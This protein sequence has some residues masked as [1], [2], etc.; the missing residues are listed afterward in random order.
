M[1]AAL[2]IAQTMNGQTQLAPSSA[3]ELAGDLAPLVAQLGSPAGL[4]T[5]GAVSALLQCPGIDD[6]ASLAR[7]LGVYRDQLL[8]PVELPAIFRAWRHASRFECRELIALDQQLAQEPM[9]R[10]FAVA[11]RHAGRNQL[12]RLRPL[13]DEKRVQ[14][15][16]KAIEAGEAN[17]WHTPVYGATLAIYSLPPRQGLLAYARQT[18]TGFA[19][20][21]ARSLRLP[22][23]DLASLVDTACAEAP[24]AVGALVDAEPGSIFL[25]AVA[26]RAALPT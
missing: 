4:A 6:H 5:L 1:A 17:G 8:V 16:L 22:P 9:L 20:S 10:P 14:R 2:L 3:A 26:A 11:S 23:A 25:P 7:F 18:L 21:A 24:Q 19:H 15:Y 12:L 13:R